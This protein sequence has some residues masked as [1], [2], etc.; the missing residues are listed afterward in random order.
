MPKLEVVMTS[1]ALAGLGFGIGFDSGFSLGSR[2]D[3]CVKGVGVGRVVEKRARPRARAGS[4]TTT[5][6]PQKERR[7]AETLPASQSAYQPV[8][9][10]VSL[11]TNQFNHT[12]PPIP[13]GRRFT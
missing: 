6:A 4:G 7:I 1:A 10:S 9:L 12:L 5:F 2:E 3:L 13:Q 11:Q 8:S